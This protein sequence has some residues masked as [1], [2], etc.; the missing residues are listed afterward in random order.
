VFIRKYILALI[1][2]LFI[3]INNYCQSLEKG[4]GYIEKKVPGIQLELRYFGTDNFMGTQV[5][6]Y[7]KPVG[8]ATKKAIRAL[9][10]VQREL[11]KKGLGLKLFDAY[12]PQTAV[13]HF[14]SWAEHLKDT[15]TKS[16]Y[17]PNVKKKNLFK[18]G[19]IAARSGHSRG[20]TVDL[21]VIN[22]KTQEELD[23]G[24]GWDFF[25]EPSW[26]SYTKISPKQKTNRNLLQQIM[27]RHGFKNYDK[28]W[29]H[30]TLKKE[31]FPDRYF[32]F[33]V[34]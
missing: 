33:P 10:R 11:A 7:N 32:D 26:V 21:T 3:G 4:F 14:I 31:P 29:W 6:G 5:N 1:L 13:N 17:Y 2:I 23:M 27:R 30:F 24:S 9:G 34:Q 8:I 25:G 28:E 20:S 18:E 15:L 12:R 16:K 19:Y 22:L